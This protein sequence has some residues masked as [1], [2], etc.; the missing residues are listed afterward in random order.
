MSIRVKDG[1]LLV[2]IMSKEAAHLKV[3]VRNGRELLS[4]LGKTRF[5]IVKDLF[6]DVAHDLGSSIQSLS[7]RIYSYA[8]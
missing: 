1:R 8:L 4:C 7:S 3:S 2:N 6:A 5:L